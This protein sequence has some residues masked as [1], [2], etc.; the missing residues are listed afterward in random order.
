MGECEELGRGGRGGRYSGKGRGMSVYTV[1][2]I[3]CLVLVLVLVLV[4]YI[5]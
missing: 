2:S 1:Y 5:V 4:H 3:Q